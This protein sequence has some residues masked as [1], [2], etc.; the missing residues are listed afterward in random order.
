M[1]YFI[2]MKLML[3]II[4]CGLLVSQLSAKKTIIK[5]ATLAPEGTDWHGMLVE[6]GQ[7]WKEATDGQVIL[8]IYPG[9]V[10]GDER[11]MIRKMRIGQIHAAAIS[12][13]GLSEVNPD[14]SG[15]VLPLIFDNYDDV[16]WLRKKMSGQLEDGMR[17]NGFEV[18]LWADIG[19]AKWFTTK[20]IVYLDDLKDMKIFTW[21]GDY[22]TQN[23]WE[24]AGFQSV[25]LASI[26]VLSGLQTGLIDAI[27]TTPLYALSQQWFGMTNYMLD[28][29]W[30]LLTAG[31]IIDS[32]IWNRIPSEH[33]QKMKAIAS[34]IGLQHQANTR[35]QD[36]E[37]IKIMKEYGLT[38]YVPTA[39]EKE[40]WKKYLD[41]WYSEL[42]GSYISEDLFDTV[43][44]YMNE[45]DSLDAAIPFLNE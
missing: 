21:A 11:D 6:M 42:R 22:R 34:D 15:F 44:K 8:R 31:V 4:I 16:D 45:K 13:E 37:A 39:E 43:I 1:N 24:S 7:R 27:A 38:V 19:W 25:P 26:D 41:A 35:H 5:L 32:R 40:A 18:L 9:G 2:K 28:I 30:G 10:V 17:E 20:P 3:R 33:Q 14:I 12:S 36:E 29:N 23:L